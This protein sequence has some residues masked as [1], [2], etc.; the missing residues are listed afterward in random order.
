M[1]RIHPRV[2]DKNH[3][4]QDKM[5]ELRDWQ[6]QIRKNRH[7]AW[8]KPPVPEFQQAE[9]D[10]AKRKSVSVL[11]VDTETG[12]IMQF[13]TTKSLDVLAVQWDGMFPNRKMKAVYT[14][15]YAKFI[16]KLRQNI[17]KQ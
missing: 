4:Q 1:V 9:Y 15:D 12:E 5:D 14:K 16:E 10:Y 7:R 8:N 11:Y 2:Q 6:K 3:Q 13:G 17:Q